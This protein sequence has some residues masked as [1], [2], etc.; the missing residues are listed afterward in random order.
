MSVQ[1]IS[2]EN[3]LLGQGLMAQDLPIAIRDMTGGYLSRFMHLVMLLNQ[4]QMGQQWN[5]V[6][7]NKKESYF[8]NK[9]YV[10]ATIKSV[11]VVGNSMT[12]TFNDTTY[13]AFIPQDVVTTSNTNIK[14]LVFE[15]GV[16]FVKVAP[17]E[18]S[19]MANLVS[20]FT[21]NKYLGMRYSSSPARYSG[22]TDSRTYGVE[23]DYNYPS[24]RRASQTWTTLDNQLS[25]P[26][27]TDGTGAYR[28]YNDQ[29][30]M[31]HFWKE[32]ESGWI[33]S[34]RSV[35]NI[36]GKEYYS[37]GG[38]DWAI[39]NRGGEVLSLASALTQ[40]T[41][42]DFAGRIWDKNS[43]HRTGEPLIIAG[44]RNGINTI[45]N[46][47][48][49]QTLN[50]GILNTFGGVDVKGLNIEEIS[51]NGMRFVLM[52][53]PFLN[54]PDYFP[55]PSTI[56]GVIGTVKSNDVYILD[57]SPVPTAQMGMLPAVEMFY[58][59]KNPFGM[60]YIKGIADSDGLSE[61]D[62]INA[63]YQSYPITSADDAASWHV[64]HRG[65]V[66]FGSAKF[67]GK[68]EFIA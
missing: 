27:F 6:K 4:K 29:V 10:G 58:F 39:K 56:P 47:Y 28:L 51:I 3:T 59:G 62:L 32:L 36:N 64:W 42:E 45:R 34:Q 55:T 67:S 16:G 12:V 31:R 57:L 60:A 65:G 50:T 33:Y 44:G 13:N 17:A 19:T 61:N 11:A 7:I 15:T 66:D 2:I 40:A 26:F 21:A 41:F 24:F 52:E 35:D 9:N 23:Y 1:S 68:I 20:E 38:I 30:R 25:K 49:G 5:P 8:Q 22:A 54:D 63:S 14:A 43:A 37:N 53:L 48:T 18:G 46:F